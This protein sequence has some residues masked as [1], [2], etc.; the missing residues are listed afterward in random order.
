MIPFEEAAHLFEE[1][2]HTAW[3]LETRRGYASDR[4]SPKW[5]RFQHGETLGYEPDHPWHAGV[6]RQT[7]E[8]K[9][10]ERVRLVDDPP[11]EGQRFL[12]ASGLGNVEAGEDIRNMYRAEARRLGL[13]DYDFWL[14]DS[15]IVMKFV[16]DDQ[17]ET[18]GVYLLKDAATVVHACQVRDKAWHYAIPTV[19]F[20]AQVPSTV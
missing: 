14:F 13:P 3:R 1:F 7:D 8:G 18:L 9:R 15:R 20:Q 19:E 6:R 10:F 2:E 12:L 4:V 17:D 11:T 16:I 5:E